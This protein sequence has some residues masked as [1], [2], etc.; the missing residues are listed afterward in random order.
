MGALP[1]AFALAAWGRISAEI[2]AA[3]DI[4]E[5]LQVEAIRLHRKSALPR[6]FLRGMGAILYRKPWRWERGRAL[7][8]DRLG[9]EPVEEDLLEAMYRWFTFA[10]HQLHRRGQIRALLAQDMGHVIRIAADEGEGGPVPCGAIDQQVLIPSED[11]LKRM[12]PCN[13][14]FCSCRWSLTDCK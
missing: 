8:A 6:D 13:H 11:V 10:T 7:L 12:P 14:P 1:D 4:K 2:E 9:E 3:P 5:A